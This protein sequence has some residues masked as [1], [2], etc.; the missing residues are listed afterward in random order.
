M[1]HAGSNPLPRFFLRLYL[2]VFSAVI[3]LPVFWT[4]YT[5]FKTTP[6]FFQD[7]WA[8][9]AALQF[10]NY[11]RAWNLASVG[12]YFIN[13]LYITGIAVPVIAILG[14]MTAYACTRLRLKAGSVVSTIFMMGIFIPT[15]LC[16]VPIFLQ[17]R[18]AGLIDR[19]LG[20][21]LLSIAEI[22]RAHV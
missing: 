6:E 18:K 10:D 20:V 5:S 1:K 4:I 16:V 9:P 14:A 17:M 12:K 22:G 3:V 8:L 2:I 19:H 13:S 15:V 7:P 21:I 11:I